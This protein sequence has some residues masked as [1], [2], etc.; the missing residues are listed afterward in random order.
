MTLAHQ[1]IHYCSRRQW[2]AANASGGSIYL[3]NSQN[4]KVLSSS[5][6]TEFSLHDL[7]NVEI[8]G[9]LSASGGNGGRIDILA[10]GTITNDLNS[11]ISA[12][13]LNNGTGGMIQ[14]ASLTAGGNVSVVN[15]GTIVADSPNDTTG[16]IAFNGGRTGAVNLSGAGTVH[17]GEFVGFG[18]INPITL[19][20]I[21]GR[22]IA[23]TPTYKGG[24]I[25]F[26]QSSA[27]T[28]Q[29]R[30]TNPLPPVPPKPP[31]P[32]NPGD[33]GN[34]KVIVPPPPI[35][36]GAHNGDA[37]AVL[38]AQEAQSKNLSTFLNFAFLEI[39]I[40]HNDDLLNE[41]LGTRIATDYTPY[42]VP[43]QLPDLVQGGVSF[44]KLAEIPGQA[45][46]GATE[47]NA[48]ELSALSAQGV[49]FG[50]DSKDNLLNL[51]QGHILFAPD[52]DITV[53]VRE[54]TVFI[55]KGAIAWV[56]ETGADS[57]IYDLHDS[58]SSGPVKV[59][60]NKKEI[61]MG[62][63]TQILLTRNQTASF[64]SLNPGS[65]VGYRR[66]KSS[67]LGGGI[68]S[69]V[70]DFS[71]AHSLSNMEVLHS[72]LYSQDAKHK[73]LVAQMLKNAA[74]LND[75]TNAA[76]PYKTKI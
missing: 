62:P 67:D 13:G 47:F 49:K 10:S 6:L 3:S 21:G 45:I 46:F 70:C 51:M 2:V 53:A 76:G 14:F 4:V 25:S 41:Q 65:S 71:I 11:Q 35:N 58:I 31:A 60:V 5:A 72:L 30:V 27:L 39:L 18:N 29:I 44:N 59:I 56:M 38:L 50:S 61:A 66:I 63:G 54:G 17:A 20:P 9:N 74:I 37:A 43:R 40:S 1:T 57:A 34:S 15:N 8:S 23:A 16:I 32:P 12:Q 22:I 24:L 68:K 55:P 48:N 64:E 75:L 36:S 42:T 19:I 26:S 7:G 73:R 28:N 69:F 33:G 52:K